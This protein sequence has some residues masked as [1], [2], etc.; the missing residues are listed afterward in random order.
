MSVTQLR[1][2]MFS[3]LNLGT[4][5]LIVDVLSITSA[6]LICIWELLFPTCSEL[7]FPVIPVIPGS[8]VDCTSGFGSRS[9]TCAISITA[10]LGL[11]AFRSS[12][13]FANLRSETFVLT[14]FMHLVYFK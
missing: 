12:I 2:S 1:A 9:G 5:T 6:V 14:E 13:S 11:D 8:C 4:S 3:S 10:G 7:S